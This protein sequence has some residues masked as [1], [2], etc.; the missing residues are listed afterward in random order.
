M[1]LYSIF[2]NPSVSFCMIRHSNCFF[3]LFADR[4]KSLYCRPSNF[5]IGECRKRVAIVREFE[6]RML[7]FY[8]VNSAFLSK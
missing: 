7:D 3:P 5:I 8:S 6:N 2:E 1:R 4:K